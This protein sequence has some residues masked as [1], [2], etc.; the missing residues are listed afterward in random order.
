MPLVFGI[1]QTG[2]L[3]DRM[4]AALAGDGAIVPGQKFQPDQIQPASLDLRLGEV[5]YRVRASFL[6]GP[7]TTVAE[8][9][10]Q[11]KLHEIILSHGAVLETGCVYIV[12]LIE[13]SRLAG[14]RCWCSQ[15]KEL[16]G[17]ARRLHP[18]NCRQN[19]GVRPH[20]ARLSRSP[21]CRDQP[22]HIPGAGA[23]RFQAVT[24]SLSP[25]ARAARFRC[26][27]DPACARGPG[28]RP[29]CRR[30]RGHCRQ[31]GSLGFN[32]LC[33]HPGG[34]DRQ[35]SHCWLSCQTSYGLDRY[36][37]ARRL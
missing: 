4:I 15:S 37:A 18:C 14:Q 26:F 23:H 3:P 17:A 1:D 6:P 22:A 20:Q 36:R 5:A 28:R 32:S 24:A 16:H 19:A 9:I 8:R 34:R 29:P 7:E 30:E 10:E 35:R 25:R 2:I 31:R 33:F 12:P 27:A 11:L 21:L 13:K